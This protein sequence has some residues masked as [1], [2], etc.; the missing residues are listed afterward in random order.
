MAQRIIANSF[1]SGE[2]SPELYGRHDLKAY[3]NGAASLE[4]FLVRRTGGIRKRAGTEVLFTL[5]TEQT[6]D[7]DTLDRKFKIFTYYYD[8]STFGLLVLRLTSAGTAQSKL[9]LRENTTS[10]IGTWTDIPITTGITASAQ[11]D[12]L[13]CK[14]VGDTLFFTR[15]GYQAFTCKITKASA[16]TEFTLLDNARTIPIP[17][18]ITATPANFYSSELAAANNIYS[19][20]H[21]ATKYYALYGVKDGVLSKPA[22][23]SAAAKTPW[24]GG[25]TI[26]VK[27]TLDFSLHDYYI[28]AKKVGMNYGKISEI[29]PVEQTKGVTA[30]YSTGDLAFRGTYGA[31]NDNGTNLL[32]GNQTLKASS[33]PSLAVSWRALFMKSTGSGTYRAVSPHWLVDFKTSGTK[34][35]SL[36]LSPTT[37]RTDT[38]APLHADPGGSFSATLTP[39]EYASDG[40]GTI[41]VGTGIAVTVDQYGMIKTGVSIGTRSGTKRFGFILE[42]S[43]AWM[44]DCLGIEAVRISSTS[45]GGTCCTATDAIL[46]VPSGLSGDA[47]AAAVKAATTLF[48]KRKVNG[49]DVIFST[50]WNHHETIEVF[51]NTS[52]DFGYSTDRKTVTGTL[53]SGVDFHISAALASTVTFTVPSADKTLASITLALGA[54]TVDWRTGTKITEK[55][56]YVTATLVAIDGAT[57][58]EVGKFNVGAGYIASQKLVIS[59]PDTA[60]P[61]TTYRLTFTK[62]GVSAPIH[63]RGITSNSINTD[64]EFVDDNIIPGA[65]TGQQDML[66]VGDNNM[67]CAV[68][69]VFEQRTVYASSALLPFSLWFSTV[70]DLY[71]F[72]AFRPQADDDAFTVTIPAKR[73]SKILHLVADKELMVF[74]EDGVYV[75]DAEG[76]A[77]FSY[78]TIR[79]RK[80]CNAVAHPD[81]QPIKVDSQTLFVGQDGRT[82]YEL[83]YD[84]MSDSIQPN[85][86][87]VLAYHLTETA[88]IVKMAYQRHPDSI[89]WCLLDDGSLISMTYMPEQEVWGWSHHTM[90][91]NASRQKIIDLAEV[92][93]LVTGDDV[94]TT[95]DILLVYE[96]YDANGVRDT[97]TIVERLRPAVCADVLTLGDANNECTDHLGGTYPA[98]VTAKL[99]TLRPESPEVSSQGIPKRVVDICLRLR[100]SGEVSVMPHDSAFS[101]N[102]SDPATENAVEETLELYSGDLKIMPAGYINDAGQIEIQS[103]D[104][105][106]CEIL[107]AV[108]TMDLP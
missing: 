96:T 67:D 14:Q 39:F 13:R 15:L 48:G 90:A 65:I 53:A 28:L 76:G 32:S 21:N 55:T 80:I 79:I 46:T 75:V 52:T 11:L 87:T 59:F 66:D 43:N 4:N 68:F 33:K 23:A 38:L 81:V 6:A 24:T 27:G 35:L 83:K 92:G 36:C 17:S 60:P 106:P 100:R 107:S 41:T 70:G 20:I 31:Y 73:A 54:D 37:V 105:R 99:V 103:S 86:K 57:E 71:N 16:K 40:S 84:L 7:A 25:A 47:N 26:T 3:F 2:I 62:N 61:T 95:S 88:Q 74:T 29:Y 1:V 102:A 9:I 91:A 42:T 89:L 51:C 56:E 77:G 58:S 64:L 85:D 50:L 8:A 94:E 5:D 45:T 19:G 10:T 78:R 98:D 69:D 101:P 72:Y 49:S 34:Y 97:Q 12:D 18:A 22:T 63:L 93:S 104:A 44:A 30:T 108:Y 82:I